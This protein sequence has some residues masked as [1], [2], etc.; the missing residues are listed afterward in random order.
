V[1]AL[2][3]RQPWAWAIARGHKTIENRSWAT[4]YRGP[5]AIHAAAKWD[6]DGEYVLR[7][8]VQRIREQGDFP[9]KTL[10]DDLPFSGTGLIVAVVDLVDICT[11]RFGCDCGP[12]AVAGETHWKLA[13]AHL[14]TGPA[15]K[16]R[17]GLWE[18]E[19]DDRG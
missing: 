4:A 13:N 18:W 3:V 11:K 16:G 1:R 5:L 10:A 17:L 2:T 6:D 8:V 12:W 19:D 7:E 15:V 14:R 9:P